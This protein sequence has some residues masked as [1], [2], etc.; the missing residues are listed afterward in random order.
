MIRTALTM[1]FALCLLLAT[2]PARAGGVAIDPV[3]LDGLAE[4]IVEAI[5][6]AQ[7]NLEQARAGGQSVVR[8]QAYAV[9]GDVLLAHGFAEQ[10]SQAYLN[11][12]A[13]APTVLDWPYLL[14]VIAAGEGRLDEALSLFDEAL[15][16]DGWDRPAL[17]RRGQV[18][19]ER[20]ELDASE[21][22]FQRL[23]QL[24][25]NSAV[26]LAGLGRVSLARNQYEQAA[27]YLER[28]LNQSPS[29]TRLF[30]PLGM[31]Y[32]GLGRS[33]DARAALARVGE[34]QPSMTDPALDRVAEQSRSA[35]YF[36]EVGLER[37]T[38]G[39]L[40]AARQALLSAL[41]L[42]PGNLAVLENYGQVAA[43]Q[44]DLEEARAT[45]R[46]MVQIDRGNAEYFMMLGQVDELRGDPSEAIAA[47]QQALTLQ[48][49]MMAAREGLAFATLAKGELAEA[50][51]RFE[52]LA[53][54]SEGSAERRFRFWQAKTWLA[55]G[56]C[57]RAADL[58]DLL[59]D[60]S[61][62]ADP[63]VLSAIARIRSSCRRADEAGLDEALEWA[64]VIYDNEPDVE[65]AATLAMVHAARGEFDDAVDFQAQAMF[66]A[67]RDGSLDYR[68]DL[69]ENMERYQRG[70]PASRPFSPGYPPFGR[71]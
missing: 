36:L 59:A 7:A 5:R 25:P 47:Y 67:L 29:A 12:R 1:T 46:R 70:E 65:S 28:A 6:V 9:Y 34:G 31:A 30:Q 44:G 19:L 14:G 13:L 71:P 54:E 24:Q 56:D 18:Q 41:A 52:T 20:G 60:S 43:R 15:D 45:F 66:E 51:Q 17:A 21:R 62:Q 63:M 68:R 23:L 11:A 40:H 39:D 64:E 27:N 3:P 61:E 55:K 48:P 35:Q 58:L 22:D 2:G 50:D 53:S 38:A 49:G 69:R 33:D 10:A 32:R 16:I 42:E 26:A 57:D 37:A 8:A 4:P